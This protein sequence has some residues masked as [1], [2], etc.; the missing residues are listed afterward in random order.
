MFRRTE[1]ALKQLAPAKVK[2]AGR[3]T[4]SRRVVMAG[5]GERISRHAQGSVEFPLAIRNVPENTGSM[6]ESRRR[7]VLRARRGAE[8]LFFQGRM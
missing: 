5:K 6:A 1:L 3:A 8:A 2:A 7:V 4:A